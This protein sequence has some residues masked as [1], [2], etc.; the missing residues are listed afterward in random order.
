MQ[1]VEVI[2]ESEMNGRDKKI[3]IEFELQIQNA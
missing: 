2:S 1:I 3:S